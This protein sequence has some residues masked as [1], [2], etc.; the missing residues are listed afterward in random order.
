MT[1]SKHTETA[2]LTMSTDGFEGPLLISLG[3]VCRYLGV[4]RT[5][6]PREP[7]FPPLIRISGN[8]YV[9]KARAEEFASAKLGRRVTI[10]L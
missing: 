3:K 9:E 5:T 10:P 4:C 7:T 1:T 6:A 2:T 8:T